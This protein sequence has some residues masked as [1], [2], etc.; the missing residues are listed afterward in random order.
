MWKD[1]IN[2]LDLFFKLE[3]QTGQNKVL[4]FV[5]GI[6]LHHPINKWHLIIHAFGQQQ[7][8]KT[9]LKEATDDDIL[10]GND[11]ELEEMNLSSKVKTPTYTKIREKGNM[12]Q[13]NYL[14]DFVQ[15]CVKEGL[16]KW[17]FDAYMLICKCGDQGPMGYLIPQLHCFM[18]F[19]CF[20]FFLLEA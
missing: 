2:R 10:A 13:S 20:C 19:K 4:S 8:Q 6:G 12:I 15:I 9:W 16:C 14:S 17:W 7:D 11:L 3:M 1:Q 5:R 18:C